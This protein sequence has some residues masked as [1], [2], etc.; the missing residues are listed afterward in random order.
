MRSAAAFFL[1]LI[2]S[3]IVAVSPA[4][5]HPTGADASA[6]DATVTAKAEPPVID[7]PGPCTAAAAQGMPEGEGHD[8]QDIELHRNLSC[9]MK[10]VAFLP[11]KEELKDR[12]DVVLGEMDVKAD[13]AAVSVIYPEGGVLFFD[14]SDPANPKFLSWYRDTNCESVV[15]ANNCGAFIDLSADGKTAIIGVQNLSGVPH[16]LE[17]DTEGTPTAQPGVQ[18]VDIRNPK[19]P[20]RGMN[21]S[22]VSQGGVHTA[23]T[24]AVAEGPAKGEYVYAMAGG[25]GVDISKFTETP[26]GRV[27]TNVARVE[28]PNIHDTF[29]QVD[30]ID[31]KTYLYIA[32]GFGSGFQVY[33][34][35]NPA[36]PKPVAEWDLTPE[37]TRDWYAHTIDVTHRGNKRYVTLPAEL[38]T[39]ANKQSASQQ[40]LGCG[41]E[42]GNGDK[43]GPMWII[44]ASDFSKLS[45]VDD[46][47]TPIDVDDRAEMKKR[48]EAALV[49]TWTNP[50]GRAGGNLTFSPHN[51]QI[52]G[53]K[54]YLSDY[55]GGVFVL[56]ASGAFAG[57]PERPR[58]LGYMVPAGDASN[59]AARPLFVPPPGS[60]TPRQRGRTNI[61]DMVFYKGY[62][63][64]ADQV[65]GFYSLQYEGDVVGDVPRDKPRPEAPTPTPT[66]TPATPAPVA[67]AS[68]AGLISATAR[69]T[70][71]NG[72]LTFDFKRRVDNPVTVD[73]FQQ[74]RGR[75]V[76]GER[77]VR[78][79]P[80]ETGSFT[81]NGRDSRGRK[82]PSGIYFARFRIEAPNGQ[83]DTV[84][85]TLGKSDGRFG[86]RRAFFGRDR[87]GTLG[88]FKLSRPVFG[89]RGA[90][91]LGIAYRLNEAARAQ[92]TVT[93]RRGRVVKR[94]AARQVEAGRTQRLT[95]KARGLERGDYRVKISVTRNGKTTTSTLTAN[96]L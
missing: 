82:V 44:D 26:G 83:A 79:F 1:A 40:A 41:V 42:Q 47:D 61:W 39:S 92:I 74:S 24:F 34:V 52:V 10:Q 71:R 87:C 86:P 53:D 58:E 6:A 68:R 7:N 93:N 33:D 54:I 75:T 45:P 46:R 31:G 80:G 14:V 11:L 20:R 9:R 88:K 56:D 18:I 89:G 65:G 96:R 64:A 69:G 76:T 19:A 27:L 49:A 21:Y 78:R 77:R 3:L 81:W 32:D 72:G 4:A 25:T 22:V 84:R 63:L 35:T 8:H 12:P 91:S 60:A 29:T 55:H 17:I 30:P 28:A 48:S 94:F 38:F 23:R 51:Q 59:E 16:P 70:G 66:S 95:L 57:R 15:F 37:C 90:R 73:V 62:V 50:A 5:A 85:V 13:I 43:V 36:S 2:L 67:C